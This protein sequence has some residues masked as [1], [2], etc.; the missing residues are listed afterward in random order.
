MSDQPETEPQ[1][2]ECLWC[3]SRSDLVFSGSQQAFVCFSRDACDS[4]VSALL[5]R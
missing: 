3:R 4:R 5:K 2:I 1:P